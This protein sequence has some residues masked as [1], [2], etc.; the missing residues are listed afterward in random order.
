MAQV[1]VIGI[2]L[3]RRGSTHVSVHV[4][5]VMD[6][7]VLRVLPVFPCHNHSTGAP[8]P[9]VVWEMNSRPYGSRS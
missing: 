2:S 1:L 6:E 3:L 5:F 9:Y 4:G 7:V 8:Y